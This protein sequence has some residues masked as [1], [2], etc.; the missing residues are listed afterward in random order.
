MHSFCLIWTKACEIRVPLKWISNTSWKINQT[1]C[2]LLEALPEERYW[3]PDYCK[4]LWWVLLNILLGDCQAFLL[5]WYLQFCHVIIA[6]KHGHQTKWW[7][8]FKQFRITYT[9]CIF[10]WNWVDKNCKIYLVSFFLFCI[11]AWR[12]LHSVMQRHVLEPILRLYIQL[13]VTG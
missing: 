7:V 3:Q 2:E 10:H 12:Q 8:G 13:F 11:V 9:T 1:G 6:R 5:G 4:S